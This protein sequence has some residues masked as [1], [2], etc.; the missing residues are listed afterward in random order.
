[1]L[2]NVTLANNIVTNSDTTEPALGDNLVSTNMPV[3]LLNTILSHAQSKTNVSGPITD[4]GH[5]ICSDSSANFISPTSRENTDPLLAPLTDNGGPTGTMALLPGSPAID[6][7]DDSLCPAADQRGVPRPI[8]VHC[9]IGAYESVPAPALIRGPSG[10]VR[11][12]F[13]GQPQRN[14]TSQATTD[15]AAWTTIGTATTDTNGFAEF[16]DTSAT[17][18]TLRFYRAIGK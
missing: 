16:K 3:T 14:L 6:A 7:G 11:V 12:Q 13:T 1:M 8:G 2:L 17:Q 18:F 5:N 10:N 9:D 4:G 15:F